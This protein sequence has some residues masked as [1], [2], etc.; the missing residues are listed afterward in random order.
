MRTLFFIAF[1]L[2]SATVL[3]A[4]RPNIVVILADDLGWGDVGWHGSE[5]KTPHLDRLAESGMRLEQFYVQP[6]CSPTR[7][8]ML[9]G[10]YPMRY[11]LQVGVIR[12]TNDFGLPTDERTLAEALREAGYFTAI[13]GK[14]HLGER[15][16]EYLPLRRG[17]DHHYGHY[18]GAID[19]YTHQR[20]GGLDWHRNGQPLREEGYSTDLLATESVRLIRE[21]DTSQPLFLYV[22]FNAVHGPFQPPREDRLNEPYK[23]MKSP[24]REYVAMVASMDENIGRIL[25]AITE[26]GIEN[27]TIVFFCSDNGGPDPGRVT[28]NGP[29]RAGKSTL[30]EG[31]VRVPACV[32]W[33]GK[34]KPQSISTQPMHIADLYPTLI[35]LAGGSLRQDKPID[36]LDM[37]DVWLNEKTFEREILHNTTVFTGALRKGDWKIVINGQVTSNELLEPNRRIENQKPRE[38]QVEVFNVKEDPCEKNDLSQSNPEKRQELWKRYLWYAEQAVP[39]LS[40]PDRKDFQSPEIWGQF[41]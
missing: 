2:F 28:S 3:G 34:I 38:R 31:G 18:L 39:H 12:P 6:V 40:V 13:C 9:T 8:A 5:I 35:G 7:A 27:D 16:P 14:W 33:P 21:H 20:D 32:V 30:Y 41:D 22:P 37:K 26:K 1:L 11:G 29:L 36:G 15:G 23:N 4:E 17:F 25:A 24:R 10:R 19:Y